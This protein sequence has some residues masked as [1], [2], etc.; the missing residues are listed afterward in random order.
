MN[1]HIGLAAQ[2]IHYLGVKDCLAHK[3]KLR[4]RAQGADV[5]DRARRKII[6]GYNGVALS[7]KA[8]AA[9]AADEPCAAGDENILQTV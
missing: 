1:D 4:V 5:F 3:L 8:L 9:M 2:A 7:Q 6:D